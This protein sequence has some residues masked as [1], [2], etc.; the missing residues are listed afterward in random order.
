MA[1]QNKTQVTE[2]SVADFIARIELPPRQNEATTLVALMTD[3]TG[4]APQM[5]G[6]SIIGF[7]SYNYK[8]ESG[9]EGVAPIVAF[10]PRK[11]QLVFY[12]LGISTLSQESLAQLGKHSSGKG[13]LYIKRLADVDQGVLHN[14]IG[15]AWNHS[16]QDAS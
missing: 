8:Y 12:G 9:R 4:A 2:V 7:G 5:W 14:L 13:C 3:I 11:A 15:N 1:Q 16:L 6:P 10:S